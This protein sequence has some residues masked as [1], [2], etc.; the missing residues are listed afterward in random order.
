M[1]DDR[2]I[3]VNPVVFQGRGFIPKDE[4]IFVVM[5]FTPKWSTVVWQTIRRR[6]EKLGFKTTRADEQ[7]GEQVLEDIWR[8]LCEASIIIA[9]VT[10]RNPNVYYELGLAHVLGRRIL[11]LTQDVHDIPFDTSIYR[12]ILYKMPCLPWRRKCELIRLS[13]EL[14]KTIN[15]IR[16]N[17]LLP[18]A[19]PLADAYAALPE[20]RRFPENVGLGTASLETSAETRATWESM[21]GVPEKSEPEASSG[22][23]RET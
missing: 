9:D 15:W 5:P 10:G 13:D 22:E 21:T 19:G 4:N 2:W 20:E 7:Y 1:N 8:G 14:E 16:E 12:H 3:L 18:T 17:E 23:A 6:M 11:L